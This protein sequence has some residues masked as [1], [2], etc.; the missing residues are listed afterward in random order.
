MRKER[1]ELNDEREKK[2]RMYADEDKMI[3]A[4]W[5]EVNEGGEKVR[6]LEEEYARR[7]DN[8]RVVLDG[9]V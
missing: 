6:K 7:L 2:L 1:G 4:R 8:E 9:A 5:D 3:Q